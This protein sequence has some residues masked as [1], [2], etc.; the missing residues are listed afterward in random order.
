MRL[1]TLLLIFAFAA[2]LACAEGPAPFSEEDPSPYR[3][4]LA[5]EAGAVLLRTGDGSNLRSSPSFSYAIFGSLYFDQHHGMI[6]GYTTDLGRYFPSPATHTGDAYFEAAFNSVSLGYNYCTELDAKPSI[7]ASVAPTLTLRLEE[8]A[9]Q[10]IR[11]GFNLAALFRLS[12]SWGLG[13]SS[14]FGKPL[15]HSAGFT[16]Q[17]Y[18]LPYANAHGTSLSGNYIGF[19][20]RYKIEL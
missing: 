20:L 8:G 17:D 16:I 19:M 9:G 13:R 7:C 2:P 12:V 18:Y 5:I 1:L 6:A 10:Q 14:H 15:S 11:F 4:D 3:S